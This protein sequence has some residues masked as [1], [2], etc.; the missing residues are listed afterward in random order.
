MILIFTELLNTENT[1]ESF[2]LNNYTNS[3]N[4]SIN[5]TAFGNTFNQKTSNNYFLD[6]STD[7]YSET[8]SDV[9]CFKFLTNNLQSDTDNIQLDSYR[10]NRN[11]HEISITQS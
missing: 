5:E 10:E 9:N 1:I 8:S 3:S 2:Q 7:D 6:E 11:E 4:D